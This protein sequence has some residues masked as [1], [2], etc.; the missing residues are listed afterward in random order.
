M[1]QETVEKV[2]KYVSSCAHKQKDVEEEANAEA[3]PAR[4]EESHKIWKQGEDLQT[5]LDGASSAG[6]E[7]IEDVVQ[8]VPRAHEIRGQNYAVISIVG[9]P[10]SQLAEGAQ[11]CR[12][13]AVRRSGGCV[14]S[15]MDHAAR[16]P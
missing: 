14:A 8:S 11:Q 13:T 7:D 15:R 9:E 5:A 16:S 4:I 10:T 12:G 3:A 6:A 1:Q 2:E